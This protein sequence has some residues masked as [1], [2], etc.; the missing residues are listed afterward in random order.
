MAERERESVY[1]SIPWF[2]SE[3]AAM[4]W[5]ELVQGQDPGT[6]SWWQEPRYFET[7]WAAYLDT[8]CRELDQKQGSQASI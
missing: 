5:A 2:T 6:A 1:V 4:A 7:S 3:M 8:F